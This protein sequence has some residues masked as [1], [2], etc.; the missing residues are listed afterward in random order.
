MLGTYNVDPRSANINSENLI[1]CK[2]GDEFAQ[3]VGQS[4]KKHMNN[5][6]PVID[7]KNIKS[8]NITKNASSKQIFLMQITRPITLL[9]DNLL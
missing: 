3:A 9:F 6:W 1:I 4:I 8:E 2:D 5:S 7:S